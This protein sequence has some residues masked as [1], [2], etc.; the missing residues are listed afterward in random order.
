MKLHI[1]HHNMSYIPQICS[2]SKTYI[3]SAATA[4]DTHA[5]YATQ[6]FNMSR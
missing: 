3:V 6:M 5:A 2:T 1:S 4:I